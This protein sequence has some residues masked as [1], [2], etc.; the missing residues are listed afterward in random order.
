MS[1]FLPFI[2]IGLTTGAVYGLA[3]TGLVLTYK[4]SGI[5]NFAYGAIAAVA[6]FVFYFLH[7]EHGMP[8]PW[9]A[10][11]V[12]FVVSPIEG[13]GLELFARILE[14]ATATLKVVA[15]IGLLLVVV[16]VGTL[17]YGNNGVD[18]PQFLDT[19]T[20]RFLGVN[21]GW[22]QI[23]VVIISLVSTAVLYY[24]FRSMRLGVAMRGVVDNPDLVS[25]TGTNPVAVRRWAWII[26]TIFASMAGLLLAPSLS[27]NAEIITLLI[28]QAFGAAAIGYFSNIPLTFVGG[29][30]VGVAGALATK[31]AASVSWLTGLSAGLPF[32][33]LFIVLIVTPRS[34]LAERRVV[35]ATALRRSWYAP[36]KVRLVAGALAIVFFCFVPSFVGVNLVTWSSALVYVMLFL[37]LGLLVKVSGQ[38]SLCH[39]AFA[40][41]GAAAFGHFTTS[42]GLPWLL[43][44]VLAGLVAVP[45][46]AIVAIPAIRLSGV[47]LALATYGFGILL[48]QMFYNTNLMF[49]PTTGGIAAPRP[50]VTIFGWHLYTDEGFYFLLLAF[51]VLNVVVVTAILK[52]RMGRLLVGLSDSPVALETH[53]ATVNVMKVLVFCITAGLAAVAGALLAS[54][55][56]YGLGANYSSFSSLTMVAV[57][58]ITVI[59]D[60]WYAILAA[61]AFVV[62]PG[63]ITVG[64][65]NTYLT[66]IFG[67]SAAT[68]A[69]QANRVVSVPLAIRNFLDRLGG[70]ATEVVPSE[71]DVDALVKQAARSER[72]SAANDR[73]HAAAK[74]TVPA[75]AK[76]GLSVSN[77]TVQYGGV[78]AVDGV[79]LSAPMGR[80]TGL[81]G[82]NGAGK[83]TTFNACSG[84]LKPT[85]GITLHGRDVTGI[86]PAG[87]SRYGL[88]RT[89][90]KAEL[91][92]SLSVRENVELGRESSMA[93]A[94]PLTQLIGSRRD[95]AVV[96]RAVDEAM[97]LTGIGPLSDLQA[98][99]LPTGQRRLVE[100]ARVLA[101]PFDLLLL[102]EPSAGLDAGE[103]VSFGNVLRG[104]V[105]ERGSGILL[106]EHDMAL[107]RQVCAHIYVLDFGRLVFEG[108]PSEM[109]N[110]DIVRA[111][112]LGS[113]GVGDEDGAPAP[114]NAGSAEGAPSTVSAQGMSET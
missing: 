41:V 114:S 13:L 40:A 103:T 17:W 89:F 21:V 44:L 99:L 71:G 42:F 105:A 90:Q 59:G 92:T 14:P 1:Q 54:L 50:N 95:R 4:T 86:G 58:T 106:V 46:G 49:G 79:S 51:V 11:L 111:A 100:L 9:A 112:Y 81:V 101:G 75:S 108:S 91:F 3:G 69:L 77:L 16:G 74:S 53:G 55:L 2:V 60:P 65:I 28:V 31:Y 18:F 82:P 78:R 45:V 38:I 80:I 52:G 43:A 35:A 23:I 22:N 72:E 63:Y 19:N 61:L 98:G 94:N 33:I 5:F 47:F 25:M 107:V 87:R 73:A 29:L 24:F 62:I 32:V 104:V 8:W 93:G 113:E 102:D 57:L 88:G 6:V 64:N 27:L 96:R 7:S 97:E 48:E 84:L 39:L 109:L 68:F 70:R 15:T 12:L 83:T 30:F 37:S 36:I 76:A 85:G 56:G 26:G 110:S 20:V 67:L 66:I 10:L 34:R